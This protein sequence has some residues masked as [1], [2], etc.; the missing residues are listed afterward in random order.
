[1]LKAISL[2]NF[3]GFREV[4]LELK[5]LT[6]LLGPNSSGKSSFGHALA[7]MAH[8]QDL[9]GGG[10]QKATLTPTNDADRWPVDL[11]RPSN[12]RT[13]GE[14]G[15]VYVG[16]QSDAGYMEFGFGDLDGRHDNLRINYCSFPSVTRTSSGVSAPARPVQSEQ[17]TGVNVA[18]PLTADQKS[19]SEN[20]VFNR[21]W[22]ESVWWDEKAKMQ[23]TVDLE[24]LIVRSVQH[25]SHTVMS[26]DNQLRDAV[27]SLLINLTYL[28]ALR[29]R[30]SR[31]YENQVGEPQAIGYSGEWAAAVLKDR[32]MDDIL[33][34]Q[35]VAV[36][37]TIE[38]AKRALNSPWK[39]SRSK[40]LLAV[41]FWLQE[42]GLADSVEA[43]QSPE[44]K[45]RLQIS[46]ALPGQQARDITEV[47]FGVSQVLPV[48][49][50]G[51]T[52]EPGSLMIVDLPEAHLHPRPQGRLADFFCSL[53]LSGKYALVETHSEIFFHQLR[54]RA[55]MDRDISENIGVY[56]IDQPKDGTCCKPVPVSLK[57]DQQIRWPVGFLEEAWDIE[58]RIRM[59]RQ[60]R[61]VTAGDKS[62]D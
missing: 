38:E 54:L 46:V 34:R 37:N 53:A 56:F 10:S 51:L 26:L 7:A 62:A 17:T 32:G 14:A 5:P 49:I 20:S 31:S 57:S 61:G 28:R 2:R 55:L 59:V 24:G 41:G 39:E 11:G 45:H 58:T 30:P 15:L 1:M 29:E 19:L 33:N 9:Y 44:D 16:L 23:V 52:Q 50:A 35:P 40:L 42:L 12:L 36:P 13:H 25:L 6:V 22:D 3:R 4:A 47:G 60:A 18:S 8:S 21:R 43:I 27:K 48:I